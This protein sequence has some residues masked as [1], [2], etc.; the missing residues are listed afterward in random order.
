MSAGT[1]PAATL[2]RAMGLR[3]AVSTSTGLAFAALQYLAAAGLV[4]YVAGDS[5]WISI[6][7]GRTAGPAGLGA[8]SAS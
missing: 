3:T 6:L 8:S 2:R 5:A 4:A 1:A 7:V